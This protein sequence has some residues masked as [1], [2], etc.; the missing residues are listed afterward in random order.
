MNMDNKTSLAH[1]VVTL[2]FC[3]LIA[4]PPKSANALDSAGSAD[5]YIQYLPVVH[6]INCVPPPAIAPDDPA[7]DLAVEA[8]INEVRDENYLPRFVKSAKLSQTALRHSN[9]M[10]D[11]NFF[12]H[13]GSDGSSVGDR[14]DAACYNWQ[15]Y[16][17]VIA[18]GYRTA[19]GVVEAWMGHPDHREILLDKSLADFGAGY[20]YN[21][22]NEYKHFWTVDFG[23]QAEDWAAASLELHT[24]NYH[25]RDEEGEIFVRLHTSQPCV[26]QNPGPP[27]SRAR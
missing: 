5:A 6:G 18:A 12:D 21:S 1:L 22:S 23:L 15:E 26:L 17:E 4:M 16:G 13:I 19:G 10:A 2:I 20:A 8:K 27:A 14:F 25:L 24:C 9:D 3:G 7:R 11:N